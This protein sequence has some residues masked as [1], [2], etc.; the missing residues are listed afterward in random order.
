MEPDERYP[1]GTYRTVDSC[2]LEHWTSEGYRIVEVW[3]DSQ[4]KANF[5]LRESRDEQLEKLAA[6]ARKHDGARQHAECVA[7]EATAR[8]KETEAELQ[9]QKRQYN[10]LHQRWMKLMDE[11]DRIHNAS[12]AMEADLGKIRREL[13]DERVRELLGEQRYVKQP[14]DES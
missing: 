5:L 11:W 7:S 12:K 10:A 6:E 8:A 9:E 1:P 14:E 2:N 13:G 3:L 4:D